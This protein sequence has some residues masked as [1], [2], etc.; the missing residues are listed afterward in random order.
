M[1]RMH[2][3]RTSDSDDAEPHV[4]DAGPVSVRAP[5]RRRRLVVLLTLALA[6]LVVRPEVA[7]AAP[8]P[9]VG[10]YPYGSP[11]TQS[12]RHLGTYRAWGPN[13]EVAA[14]IELYHSDT[15]GTAWVLATSVRPHDGSE[16]SIWNPGQPSQ[17]V[18]LASDTY[19]A[20]R[21]V[22]DRPGVETCV[23]TQVYR[24]GRWYA[25]QVQ[26]CYR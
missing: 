7:S 18:T 15:C 11:C 3:H 1:L 5:R 9:W 24:Y 20:T 16:V 12:V 25:W 4:D 6:L 13:G 22:D 19:R 14:Y 23:G 10:V 2:E 8:N 26:L 21:M 17:R